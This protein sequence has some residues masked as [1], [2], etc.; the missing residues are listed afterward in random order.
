MR[1]EQIDFDVIPQEINDHHVVPFLS[2][3][4][5]RKYALT[6]KRNLRVAINEL[7]NR[8]KDIRIFC[9]PNNTFIANGNRLFA[10]GLSGCGQLG[11]G[12][13]TNK[14]ELTEIIDIKGKVINVACGDRF[15]IIQTNVNTYIAGHDDWYAQLARSYSFKEFT[16]VPGK[17]IS[18]HAGFRHIVVRTKE[19]MNGINMENVY[20][21]GANSN[22]EL[23]L[24]DT[25]LRDTFMKLPAN[26]IPGDILGIY[27][28][29]C[30]T[31]IQTNKGVYVCGNNEFGQLGL[32]HTKNVNTFTKLPMDNI[33]GNILNIQV[34]NI[35]IIIK[36]DEGFF[37]AGEFGLEKPDKVNSFI[38]LPTDGVT[39]D[40]LNVHA[41]QCHI[42]A[43]TTDGVFV[44]GANHQGQLGLG[45]Q[46]SVSKFTKLEGIAG[47]I[48]NVY[49]AGHH[50][51]VQTSN[52]VYTF[53][54][55]SY[56]QLGLGDWEKKQTPTVIPSATYTG[57]ETQKA[58][59]FLTHVANPHTLAENSIFA[60]KALN[61]GT[62]PPVSNKQEKSSIG[63][64][65]NS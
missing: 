18:V 24:G 31:I 20:V 54:A 25:K 14:N 49:A 17:I 41:G 40:I 59:S 22:G 62:Q 34:G 3:E 56:G 12:Q 33:P 48:Q 53:G 61:E 13:N 52:G 16:G 29:G 30:S 65:S 2:I 46:I 32:G 57:H 42:I 8:L 47:E 26:S 21:C 37:I 15:C 7:E 45:A 51:I 55:N 19:V 4:A 64:K 11:G 60:A 27:T 10:S 58:Y 38:M 9:Y 35:N 1:Q 28:G 44:R 39:G 63:L 50:T 5:L 43:Q 36:T 23:G 6:N